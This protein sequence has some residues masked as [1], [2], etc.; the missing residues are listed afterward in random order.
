M[1]SFPKRD[2]RM[3][4]PLP[5]LP[6]P[7]LVLPPDLVTFVIVDNFAISSPPPSPLYCRTFLLLLPP[8]SVGVTVAATVSVFLL[9]PPYSV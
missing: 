1:K 6:A 5:S 3:F 7:A 4:D 2:P 8:F 9:P